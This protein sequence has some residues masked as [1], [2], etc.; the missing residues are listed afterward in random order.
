MRVEIEALYE[1]GVL[2]PIQQLPLQSGQRVRLTLHEP[3]GRARASAGIFRW[4]GERKDLEALLGPD[5][6]PWMVDE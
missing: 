6:H 5:N 4:H 3:G 2:K 1:D